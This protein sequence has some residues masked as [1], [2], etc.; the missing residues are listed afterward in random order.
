MLIPDA[1]FEMGTQ[2]LATMAASCLRAAL[3]RPAVQSLGC[4]C[5]NSKDKLQKAREMVQGLKHLP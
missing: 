2:V 3:F 5:Y 1:V 4:F